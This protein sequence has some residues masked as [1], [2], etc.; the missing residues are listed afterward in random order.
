MRLLYV[1]GILILLVL[2]ACASY[3]QWVNPLILP[4][5][6]QVIEGAIKE[7][8][9]G[10]LQTDTT[11]SLYR[12]LMGFIISTV[13]ALPIGVLMGVSQ[14][15]QV[16]WTPLVA[17]FRYMPTVAF[18]PLSIVW[19]GVTDMQKFFILFM[20]VFFQEV[21]M[22]ADNCK[23]VNKAFVDVGMTLGLRRSEIIR[24]IIL[25]AASPGIVDTLRTTW[26]WAWTYLLVA[27]L[28]AASQGL[29]FHIMQA[30]R[31][32]ATNEI[33]LGILIIGFLGLF[34]DMLFGFLYQRL[35]PWQAG[36]HVGSKI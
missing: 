16:F 21:I 31:Y 19:F 7:W 22:I 14:S 12:I 9:D 34:T 29:G 8:K 3:L 33:I 10:T 23:T 32:L 5:P 11:V 13:F 18:V 6:S 20:G 4:T 2:W 1:S 17:L 26:G 15:W 24:K 35:F 27:E 28:V 25:P 36:Q 30:Q